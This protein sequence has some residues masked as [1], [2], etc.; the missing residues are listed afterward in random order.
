MH[1][2]SGRKSTWRIIAALMLTG[3]LSTTG[4]AV[5]EVVPEAPWKAPWQ[6]RPDETPRP[7]PSE[8][9]EPSAPTEEASS[10]S[11]EPTAEASGN[12]TPKQTTSPK[13][14][15]GAD[16]PDQWE[17]WTLTTAGWGPV[18]MDEPIPRKVRTAFT[19]EWECLGPIFEQDGEEIV[20]VFTTNTERSGRIE[21]IALWSEASSTKSG[22]RIGDPPSK[23]DEL[24][25]E[26][27]KRTSYEHHV[28]GSTTVYELNDG[29]YSMFFE[30]DSEQVRQISTQISE[31]F[32]PMG[33]IGPC[34]GP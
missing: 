27:K 5:I 10:P 3:V 30:V 22:L 13:Q 23:V 1:D 6:Q 8:E 28:H 16:G 34:G 19:P 2:S 29:Y 24:Y 31:E 21:M 17:E 4:C 12:A 7:S 11:Q 26:A 32:H 20:M 15:M 14:T 25:P 9:P 33:R 18:R